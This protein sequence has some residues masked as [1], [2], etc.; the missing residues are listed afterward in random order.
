MTCSECFFGRLDQA[1]KQEIIRMTEQL[2]D[3]INRGDYEAYTKIC[4][5]H[6]TAF[7]PEALGNLVEGME[8]HKFYFDH[9]PPIYKTYEPY[10]LAEVTESLWS[11]REFSTINEMVQLIDQHDR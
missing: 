8:F 5:P 10:T 2:V 9:A 4:D 6:L 1:R 11:K 3:S 7:E